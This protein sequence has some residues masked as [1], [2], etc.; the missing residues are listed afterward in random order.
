VSTSVTYTAVLNV[1]RSTAEHVARL[2]RDHRTEV[3]TRRGRRALG[4]F[5]QAAMVLR[6]FIDGTR[7][8]QLARDNGLSSSNTT[9]PSKQL[10]TATIAYH[11][12]RVAT[13]FAAALEPAGRAVAALGT[14]SHQLAFL[15]HT[16]SR[17]NQPDVR[18][19]HEHIPAVIEDALA[20]AN[21]T[22]QDA[23]TVLH[24]AATSIA[25]PAL[26]LQAALSRTTTAV[27]KP[28]PI[29][30]TGSAPAHL[31]TPKPTRGR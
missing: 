24:A 6:W 7:M 20:D 29:P 4:P 18:D 15:D 26:R 22:L 25:Q 23:A 9:A 1:Q 13:A 27:T 10:H 3:G 5:R 14:V 17:R 2:L 12:A 21:T 19:V 28:S 30:T 11:D 31:V 8:S 16:W